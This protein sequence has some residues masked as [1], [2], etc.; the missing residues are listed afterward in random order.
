MP[1]DKYSK[2]LGK[3]GYLT[4]HEQ[5]KYHKES[6]ALA[7]DFIK[8]YERPQDGVLM[9]LD[10]VRQLQIKENRERLIPIIESIIFLGRQNLALRGHRDHDELSISSVDEQL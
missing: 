10:S 2:L 8:I 6:V 3:Y 5:N 9:K 4:A 1:L 7:L